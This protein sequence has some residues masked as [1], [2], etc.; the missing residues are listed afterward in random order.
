[1]TEPAAKVL[2]LDELRGVRERLREQ[3]DV[4]VQCH[5]CFDIVHPGHIRHLSFAKS[6]GDVLIVTITAD[7]AIEKGFDRPYI[8]EDL[9]AENLAALAAVD[10]IGVDESASALPILEALRPD[11][12]VKGK[13][14]ESNLHPHFLKEKRFVE[15]YGGK[16]I[17]SSGDVVYSSTYIINE[18]RE[19]FRFEQARIEHFCRKN[20]VSAGGIEKTLA[21]IAGRKVLVLADAVLDHYI[22]CDA[23]GVAAEGPV[24]DVTP[25]G[26]ERFV[27]AGALVA[28]QM[29]ALGAAPTFM[30]VLGSSPDT[31]VFCGSLEA[32]GVRPL[33]LDADDR[34]VYAKTRYLV[35][36]AKVFKIST[37]QPAPL[38]TVASDELIRA[39]DEQLADH[40]ALAVIDFGYGFYSSDLIRAVIELTR[41]HGRPYYVDVSHTPKANILRFK[42]H[43]VGT[44]TE[45][46]LRFAFADHESG[47]SNL[48][49]RYYR[50]TAAD[51]LVLTLG[52]KGALT[53]SP[54]VPGEARLVADYLPALSRDAPDPVGAGDVFHAGILL[55]D[56]AGASIHQAIYTGS[57]LSALHVR[58]VGNKPVSLLDLRD[59]LER[60][61]E[62]TR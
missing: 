44:P 35:D 47:L 62:L 48:A 50:E 11:I 28:A 30:T 45:D 17:Y 9:R 33:V 32:A 19:R 36:D 60:R 51:R 18:F 59:Y 16:V 6:Q 56:L 31:D 54:P 27:G 55:S 61:P 21:D 24:L 15:S 1:M 25:L 41:R 43:R 57:C 40:E 2:P 37:G 26:E 53:F 12:Y 3:G 10:Y 13:E 7:A 22:H 49:A 34:P 52:K 23:R 29:S 38:S 42:G 14:Y 20:D 58:R 46:E 5:G 39:L 4:V 8:N